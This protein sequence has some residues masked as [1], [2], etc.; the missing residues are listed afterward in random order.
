MDDDHVDVRSA[1]AA[2]WADLAGVVDE[3]GTGR[4]DRRARATAPGLPLRPAPPGDCRRPPPRRRR[5]RRHGGCRAA[6]AEWN[7]RD[8]AVQAERAGSGAARR[9]A[10]AAARG[11]HATTR[12]I[13]AA[14]ECE[15]P[16]VAQPGAG[17]PGRTS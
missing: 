13:S 7:D 4:P 8:A 14:A 15:W 2:F 16:E 11:D 10:L 3:L 17:L 12:A 1:D 5:P 9:A 6:R